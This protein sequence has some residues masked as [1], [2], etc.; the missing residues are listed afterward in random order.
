MSA[1]YQCRDNALADNGSF[2]THAKVQHCHKHKK[3]NIKWLV[4]AEAAYQTNRAV[5]TT[6]MHAL[7]QEVTKAKVM[8]S[9]R[10]PAP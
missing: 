1:L 5:H 3:Q 2:G 8:P 4:T 9:F 6:T 7:A 10:S